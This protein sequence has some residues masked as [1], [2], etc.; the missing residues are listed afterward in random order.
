MCS[1]FLWPQKPL[2]RK[3]WECWPGEQSGNGGL[4][5]H[6]GD[7][8]AVWRDAIKKKMERRRED[9]GMLKKLMKTIVC[10]IG[11]WLEGSGTKVCREG[12]SDSWAGRALWLYTGKEEGWVLP[13]FDHPS[14]FG[15]WQA[16]SA[17][18]HCFFVRQC[19]YTHRNESGDFSRVMTNHGTIRLAE[20]PRDCLVW[21]SS[22]FLIKGLPWNFFLKTVPLHSASNSLNLKATKNCIYSLN[23]RKAHV[24]QKF[25]KKQ[26]KPDLLIL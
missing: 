7:V 15:S 21:Q 14:L 26:L 5:R 11:I 18:P 24:E 8:T 20:T 10:G 23:W 4:G 3:W 1:V 19:S 9:E 16:T 25:S 13:R 2:G 22:I 6:A 17:S 12:S